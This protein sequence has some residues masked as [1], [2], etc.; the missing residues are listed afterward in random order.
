[1]KTS[2]TTIIDAPASFVFR[3]LLD[4]EL[5][6]NWVSSLTSYSRV[7]GPPNKVGTTYHSEFNLE[8]YVYE[9]LSEI[10]AIRSNKSILWS[11]STKFY[12]GEVEYVLT[13]ISEEQTELKYV[14]DGKHKGF[15]KILA[16]LAKSKIREKSENILIENH[17]N[18]K[19]YA[20]SLYTSEF[21]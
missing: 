5:A 16:W 7:S 10:K 18:F 20:E 14:S 6:T 12:D 21:E 17:M 1:M 8:G 2:D 3:I 19:R 11:C 13:P 15:S 9:Q 4:V